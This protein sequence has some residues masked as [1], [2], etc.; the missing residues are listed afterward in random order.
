MQHYFV[1]WVHEIYLLGQVQANY[2]QI[3]EMCSL[4][5]D[6]LAFHSPRPTN[7]KLDVV[8]ALLHTLNIDLCFWRTNLQQQQRDLALQTSLLFLGLIGEKK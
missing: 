6:L 4:L 2:Q 1:E 8:L 7:R 3:D 5:S